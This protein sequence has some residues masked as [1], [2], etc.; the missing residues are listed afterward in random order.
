MLLAWLFC[1]YMEKKTKR[2]ADELMMKANQH[3]NE[4]I[5]KLKNLKVELMEGTNDK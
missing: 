4:D 1:H 3:F 2:E 5:E